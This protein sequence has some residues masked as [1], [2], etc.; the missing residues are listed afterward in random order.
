MG[1]QAKSFSNGLLFSFVLFVLL[2]VPSL[3]AQE[4]RWMDIQDCPAKHPG[5]WLKIKD[6]PEQAKLRKELAAAGKIAFASN[7]DGNWEIY[8]TNPDGTG[9]KNLTNHPGWDIYPRWTPEGKII[10]FSDRDAKVKMAQITN[11]LM[12]GIVQVGP[13]ALFRYPSSYNGSVAE[14]RDVMPQCGIY[15]MDADGSNVKLL[16]K[17]A[18]TA[19]LSPDGKLLTFERRGKTITRNLATSEEFDGV[20]RYFGLSRWPEF[21]PD[22][23][24]ILV[25]SIGD[26]RG[27]TPGAL[28][29]MA[30][31][32]DLKSDGRPG[33][34]L[35]NVNFGALTLCPRWR[36]DGKAILIA[37]G[38]RD[39]RLQEIDLSE[40]PNEQGWLDGKTIGL[41]T[42]ADKHIHA[43]PAYAPKT[44]HVAFSLAPLHFAVRE[45]IA[46][47]GY[48][49]WKDGNQ[50][51]WQELCVGRAEAGKDN[52]W[53]QLT[54]GGYANRDAD[55]FVAR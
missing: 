29:L 53:I 34:P 8:V 33:G 21:S 7:R 48:R 47:L 2:V 46:P 4:K 20:Q 50:I 6:S 24:R 9:Q 54:E 37:Q 26:T 10:F 35:W 13:W 32:F 45:Q 18:R 36:P 44:K 15:M 25:A 27:I 31:I 41:A 52:D 30:T 16:V 3:R 49:P 14:E 17:E 23:K 39:N 11:Q 43:F 40:K 1:E 19:S 51:V 22:G 55:W 42:P 38:A 12:E 28:N 5:P